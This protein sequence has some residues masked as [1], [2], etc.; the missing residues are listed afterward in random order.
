M[1]HGQQAL[2][3]SKGGYNRKRAARV[4][5]TTSWMIPRCV[6][7]FLV[8]LPKSDTD[9]K[10]TSELV[11]MKQTKPRYSWLCAL[12]TGG[13]EVESRAAAILFKQCM[14]ISIIDVSKMM[15]IT[16]WQKCARGA[17]QAQVELAETQTLAHLQRVDHSGCSALGL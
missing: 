5:A 15:H 9:S 4:T 8:P 16:F 6:M 10:L 7:V 13:A 3:P 14:Y 17:G 2:L 12:P 11:H 1:W